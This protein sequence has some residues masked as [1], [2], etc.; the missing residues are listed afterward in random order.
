MTNNIQLVGRVRD[1]RY[2][3][4]TANNQYYKIKIIVDS[5]S[6]GNPDTFVNLVVNEKDLKNKPINNNELISIVG[7]L[8]SR[9]D[10]EA[11]TT[12]IYVSSDLRE[13]TNESNLVELSGNVCK[14][15][16]YSE[17]E[18]NN[19]FHFILANFYEVQSGNKVY[20]LNSYIPCLVKGELAKEYYSKVHVSDKVNLIGR[21]KSHTYKKDGIINNVYDVVVSDIVLEA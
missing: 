14:I 13:S 11:H 20:K 5:N 4:S 6:T 3:H 10:N 1:I 9:N 16:G 21:L 15:I 12:D 2:S 18:Y 19:Y 7:Y 8:R 17:T